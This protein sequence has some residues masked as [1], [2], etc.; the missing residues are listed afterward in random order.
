MIDWP[1]FWKKH[2]RQWEHERPKTLERRT[3]ILGRAVKRLWPIKGTSLVSGAPAFGCLGTIVF[4][5]MAWGIWKTSLWISPFMNS[6]LRLILALGGSKLLC[7]FFRRLWRH[8][9]EE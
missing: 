5:I 2:R 7:D 3:T 8:K 1:K 6:L 4:L 9:E